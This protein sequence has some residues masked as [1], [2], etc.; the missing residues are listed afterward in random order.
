MLQAL[1]LALTVGQA[2]PS[3]E[4]IRL[5][6]SVVAEFTLGS[7][8][9]SGQRVRQLAWSPDGSQLYLMTYDAEKDASV[10]KAYHYLIPAAPGKFER[11]DAPP[12][13]VAAYWTWKSD[14]FAPGDQSVKIEVLEETRRAE[15][16]VATP[17]GGD[18]ARGGADTGAAGVSSGAAVNAARG[19][20]MQNVYSLKLKDE[21]VGEFIDHP[22]VPGLTFGWAPKANG[23]IAF[24][25]K[26]GGRLVLMDYGG[27]KQKVEGTRAVVLP[28][29]SE[30]GSRIAYL[31]GRG[32]NRFALIV[33]DVKK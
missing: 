20:Q 3:V 19:M 26:D 31:E 9:I 23:I 24:A 28:G 1:L 29:F 17:M 30:D 13:W 18:F 7:G 2:A 12:A 4:A 5:A 10:K 6:P 25:E 33:A 27:K 22:I 15:T 32:R 16:G 14:R 8:G 11:V 21:I